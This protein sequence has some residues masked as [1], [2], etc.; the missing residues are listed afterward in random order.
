MMWSG[1]QHEVQ[2]R[3]FDEELFLCAS[4]AA[5]TKPG[6]SVLYLGIGEQPLDS[7]PQPPSWFPPIAVV[8][9]AQLGVE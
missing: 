4:K 7:T 9:V 5:D 8:S 2:Q 6:H 1:Q 3:C